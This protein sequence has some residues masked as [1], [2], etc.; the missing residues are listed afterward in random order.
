MRPELSLF[1]EQASTIASKVDSLYLF[2]LAISAF[3]SLLIALV[4]FLFFIKYRRREAG[5]VGSQAHGSMVLEVVWSGPLDPDKP[6]PFV[7]LRG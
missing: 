7:S 6:L 1:P 2:A 5:E 3:F 4:I